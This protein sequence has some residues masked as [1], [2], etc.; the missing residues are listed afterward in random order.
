L[1]GN[2]R[3]TDSWLDNLARASVS[4]EPAAV[5]PDGFLSRRSALR[6]GL[7]LA[8]G[9]AVSSA[10]VERPPGARAA[11]ASVPKRKCP[12]ADVV[13]HGQCVNT[14]TN[15]S[16]CGKCGRICR[17]GGRCVNGGCVYKTCARGLTLCSGKCVKLTA[18]P[19]H[20][21][22]CGYRCPAGGRCVK[23]VCVH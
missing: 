18:H 10:V 4:E 5:G 9:L 17:A 23:G 16:N 15:A 7:G 2:R 8:I 20:C 13:C 12:P 21:G 1:S 14:A 11:A 22:T 6:R 19:A 3:T